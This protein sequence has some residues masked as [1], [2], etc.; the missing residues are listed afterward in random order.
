M[1][2]YLYLI[3]AFLVVAYSL[4]A[5]D[6]E[7]ADNRDI[8]CDA[9]VFRSTAD[10]L[11][12][13]D[14]Y[15]LVPYKT[16][17]FK[18]IGQSYCAKYSLVVKAVD[19]TGRA[20]AT[21]QLTRKI[22]EQDYAKC[23]G[24]NG[25]F[26]Y[27]QTI[28]E[29]PQGK[30]NVSVEVIDDNKNRSFSK[31]RTMKLVDFKE[32][33]FALSGILLVSSIEES[34]ESYKITPHISDNVGDL[35]DG[36]FAFFEAYN[37]KNIDSADF[38]YEVFDNKSNSVY[39]SEKLRLNLD[40][41]VNQKFVRVKLPKTLK[42]GSYVLRIYALNKLADSNYTEK[43]YLA[44]TE[45]SIRLERTVMGAV[46]D[47]L[48]LAIMQLAYVARSS[49]ID[50]IKNAKTEEDKIKRFEEFW[51]KH[52]PT[53]DTDLNEAFVQ[54]YSRIDLANQKFKSYTD[55]WRSDMG[56]V[57][58]VYG[59]P[60]SIE[61]SNTNTPGQVYQKWTYSNNK[62]FIFLDNTGFG[63]YRLYSPMAISDKYVYGN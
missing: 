22:I 9:I 46:M 7:L 42:T 36:F 48:D 25:D 53:P 39:K 23:Q 10:S 11:N 20:I 50:Y 61:K 54:Y 24:A 13:V 62:T 15:C 37:K 14:I 16:V 38:V 2:I 35:N 32:Y 33:P 60:Y 6:D 29:L 28:F 30:Y 3:C 41:G 17:N 52:D 5:Q 59:M 4:K 45:R 8:F 57:F 56:A 34:G 31:S 49:E 26:D 63:D 19:S 12:R 18:R 47:N 43:D 55:G 40:S 58:V 51:K 27:S 44:V 1:R 21:K